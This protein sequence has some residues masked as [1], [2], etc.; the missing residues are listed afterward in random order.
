MRFALGSSVGFHLGKRRS[1][2]SFG[3]KMIASATTDWIMAICAIIMTPTA[4]IQVI[5]IVKAARGSARAKQA[6]APTPDTDDAHI[7]PSLRRRFMA[8]MTSFAF[9]FGLAV[10]ELFS[11]LS[12]TQAPMTRLSA[13]LISCFTS[14]VIVQAALA[15]VAWFYLVRERDR[16]SREYVSRM[17]ET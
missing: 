13:F 4:I 9:L 7:K 6:A 11:L 8:M 14:V 5:E 16:D 2:S 10:G 12:D 15:V 1:A 3:E 17:P